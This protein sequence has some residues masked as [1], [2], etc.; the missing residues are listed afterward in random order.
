MI[1]YIWLYAVV[2]LCFQ[3]NYNIKSCAGI[4]LQ[5]KKKK[6]NDNFFF[7]V[8]L[9]LFYSMPVA[10]TVIMTAR[11]KNKQRKRIKIILFKR[12]PRPCMYTE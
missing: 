12:M 10:Q 11:G 8:C 7:S 1:A 9:D 6:N 2:P 4:F 5:K 3:A